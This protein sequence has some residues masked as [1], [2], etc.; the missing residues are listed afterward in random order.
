MAIR[1]F[2]D[3]CPQ[4]DEG[5]YCAPSAEIIGRVHLMSHSSV[6]FNSVIRGD[7]NHIKI[8]RNV[9]VQDLCMLHVTDEYDLT[10][11]DNTS[12]G[13]SVILHGCSI[14]A[15]CLIGM[16]SIILDGAVIGDHCLVAA[17]S[18]IPPGRIYPSGSMIKGRPALVERPLTA[19]EL[20]RVGNHYQAY[21]KYKDQYLAMAE[22]DRAE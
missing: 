11:G 10:I 7:V 8:G 6:F 13:H 5:V 9:N 16:G 12:L 19:D 3:F 14:G 18:L 2:L 4:L 1:K 17:G 21:L 15:G 22:E 20:E